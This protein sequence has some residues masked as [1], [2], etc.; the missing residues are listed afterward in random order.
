[1]SLPEKNRIKNL[2]ILKGFVMILMALDHTR[3]YF[4]ADSFVFDPTNIDKSNILIFLTRWVTHFCA[5]AFSMLAGVSAFIMGQKKTKAELSA[6]LLKRGLWLVFIELTVVNFAWF[7]DISFGTIG[8]I[9]IWSLGVSM[10]VLSALV[11][12]P[13]GGILAFSIALIFGHN[14]LDSIHFGGNVIWAILHEFYFYDFNNGFTFFVGYPLIPWIAVMSLGYCFGALYKKEVEPSKRSNILN[15]IGISAVLLF[16]VLRAFNLYGNPD[17]WAVQQT[18]E[19][20]IMS[21]LNVEKYPPS[22]LYLLITLGL[23]LLFLAN[24]EKLKGKI[25]D[26]FSTF[27]RVPFFFY[28]IHIYVIHFAAIFAAGFT[29]F[30]WTAM[31]LDGWVGSSENLYGYGFSLGITY[32]VWILMIAITY[33]ICKKFDTYKQNNREKWWLSYL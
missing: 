13:L 31:F 4:H 28:I 19:K 10:I 7:F 29:G 26:F 32:L 5:P 15:F 17:Y 11:Y 18:L 33:P 25:V 23:S 9:T 24:S 22:L 8:L 21:F 3:D 16:L 20:S 2:D 14:L 27:G 12:L 1:M 30:G 6:F